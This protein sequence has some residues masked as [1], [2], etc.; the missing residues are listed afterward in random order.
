M[1][2]YPI[3]QWSVGL[4]GNSVTRNP[5]IFVTPDPN[6]LEMARKNSFVVKCQIKGSDSIYDKHS[7]TGVI[8]TSG[9]VPNCR[10]N[11]FDKTGLYVIRLLSNW[12]GYPNINGSVEISNVN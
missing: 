7:I 10:P 8:N 2:T 9:N 4:T 12:Y 5:L 1:T 3:K 11:F 6:F